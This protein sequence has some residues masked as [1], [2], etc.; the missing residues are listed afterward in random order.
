MTEITVTDLGQKLVEIRRA[1]LIS[2]GELAEKSGISDRAIRGIEQGTA[3]AP[4]RRTVEALSKEL[5]IDPLD[6]ANPALTTAQVLRRAEQR[7]G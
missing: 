2:Q 1:R 7:G 6:L 5:G 3:K 4:R